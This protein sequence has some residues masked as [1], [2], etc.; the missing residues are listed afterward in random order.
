[1]IISAAFVTKSQSQTQINKKIRVSWDLLER[2]YSLAR[3][4]KSIIKVDRMVQKK[5]TPMGITLLWG[6]ILKII[7]KGSKLE[8]IKGKDISL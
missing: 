5:N 8:E 7:G 1:M 6:S 2:M 4:L 3:T